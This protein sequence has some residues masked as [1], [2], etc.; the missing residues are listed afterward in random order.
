MKGI[1]PRCADVHSA[2]QCVEHDE[3]NVMCIGAQIVALARQGP[4]AATSMQILDGGGICRRVPSSPTWMRAARV[5]K[6]AEETM[7]RIVMAALASRRWWARA[8]PQCEPRRH[9][10]VGKIASPSISRAAVRHDRRA[11]AAAG[12]DVERASCSPRMG[13][14]FEHVPTPAPR[15]SRAADRQGRLVISS[16]STRRSA[17]R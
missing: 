10:E 5:K 16:L 9:Q 17:P 7:K 4:D 6:S 3:S 8:M 1:A 13:L 2:H 15:A 11:D 12:L 14:Q